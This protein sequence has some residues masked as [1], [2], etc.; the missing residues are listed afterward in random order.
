MQDSKLTLY[1]SYLANIAGKY[2][3]V[4]IGFSRTIV[5][6]TYLTKNEM[7][8]VAL[9]FLVLEYMMT[10]LPMG[11]PNSINLL[12]SIKK[13]KTN[14]TENSNI[15]KKIYSTFYISYFLFFSFLVTIFYFIYFKFNFLLTKTISDNIHLITLI[16]FFS[17]LKIFTNVHNRLWSK[18]HRLNF[19]NI[20]YSLIYFLG[21]LFIIKYPKIEV[22]LYA[23]LLASIIQ[24]YFGKLNFKFSD[25]TFNRKLFKILFF[26]GI[27]LMMYNLVE[28]Y[29]W[30]VDRM[31]I[32]IFL[33]SE[34]LADFHISHTFGKSVMMS[35]T[36]VA[37]LALPKAIE[38]YSK[39][40]KTNKKKDMLFEYFKLSE[41]I[42]VIFFIFSIW[43]LPTLIGY[44]LPLYKD[45]DK[46]FIIIFLGL[47]LKQLCYFSSSYL[48]SKKKYLYLFGSS[49]LLITVNLIFFLLIDY[50]TP[51]DKLFNETI[52][53]C[54]SAAIIFL[55]FVIILNLLML[56]DI[57]AKNIFVTI[58]KNFYKIFISTIF[59]CFFT[60]VLENT[61]YLLVIITSQILIV[62][63]LQIK[64]D[65]I[66][67]VKKIFEYYEKLKQKRLN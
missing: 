2:F 60:L 48:I 50:F 12:C 31:L 63:F 17:A 64:K 20:S 13:G 44:F 54:I 37:N 67:I 14:I 6:A 39:I 29:F 33:T 32:S 9:I 1:N 15:I 36:V 19:I 47:V 65:I 8:I 28:L 23:T 45:L 46:I 26:S 51:L 7:G 42:L 18:F 55:I 22:L 25:L 3:I 4:A 57:E 61:L 40:S 5:V 35:L 24:V 66:F 43:I 30:G 41:S 52:Y 38:F 11:F 49:F 27:I 58:I 21:S 34:N 16:I 10:I 59:I 53:F 62:Y 56:N